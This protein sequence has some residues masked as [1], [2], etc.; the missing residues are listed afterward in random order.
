MSVG[1]EF[2]IGTLQCGNLGTMSHSGRTC[3]GQDSRNPIP[4]SCR[5]PPTPSSK[6]ST[7]TRHIQSMTAAQ[8]AQ[9]LDSV[10][11]RVQENGVMDESTAQNAMAALTATGISAQNDAQLD[12]IAVA[13]A[14]IDVICAEL[15]ITE[16][17]SDRAL[18]EVVRDGLV[19]GGKTALEAALMKLVVS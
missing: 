7:S 2:R 9:Q 3:A 15:E 1:M 14:D 17:I 10:T 19:V 18:R 11:D 13:Q 12:Q 4:P 6:P 8:E 16:D 5:Q